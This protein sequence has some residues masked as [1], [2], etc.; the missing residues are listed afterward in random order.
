MRSTLRT[1]LIAAAFICCG[2][3]AAY[4][5]APQDSIASPDVVAPTDPRLGDTGSSAAPVGLEDLLGMAV[6]DAQGERLGEVEDVEVAPDGQPREIVV[7]EGRGHVA[8]M[9]ASRLKLSA[10]NALRLD[11]QLDGRIAGRP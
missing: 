3:G 2:A 7:D 5:C 9:D 10:P 11:D 1:S 6:L 4:A 8:R